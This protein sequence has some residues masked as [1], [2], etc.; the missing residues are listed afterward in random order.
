MTSS[1]VSPGGAPREGDGSGDAA[2]VDDLI[3]GCRQP[4]TED[5]MT[6]D[7]LLSALRAPGT[8]DELRGLESTSAVF[9]AARSEAAASPVVVPIAAGSRRRAVTAGITAAALL[10][11]LGLATTAAAYTGHLPRGLQELAS[12][13][14]GAPAPVET[15]ETAAPTAASGATRSSSA[16]GPG[17]TRSAPALAGLC[18]AFTDR[19]AAFAADDAVGYRTLKAA[20]D[21]AGVSVEAYCAANAPSH[22]PTAT[23]ST[24]PTAKPSPTNKPTAVPSPTS[25][26]T[27]R[28][29]PTRPTQEPASGA[30]K[31]RT[32]TTSGR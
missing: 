17:V 9:L 20:A 24:K 11:T 26:P 23:P 6:L 30:P 25:K 16:Q 28:P 15:V 18:Q 7:R 8:A 12:E 10:A 19:G 29:T 4:E 27:T 21:K 14:I 22:G 32:S 13:T 3:D 5:D 31:A 2:A 1:D